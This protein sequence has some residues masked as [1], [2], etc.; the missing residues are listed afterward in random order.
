MVDA[1]QSER[2][3]E[4][5]ATRRSLFDQLQQQ[6]G[7]H[8]WRLTDQEDHGHDDQGTRQAPVMYLTVTGRQVGL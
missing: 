2:R 8:P 1:R 6:G 7:Q 3:V 4:N 5:D